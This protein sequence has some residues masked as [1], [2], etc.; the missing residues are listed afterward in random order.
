[1]RLAL[2]VLI[3]GCVGCGGDPEGPDQTIEIL[4]GGPILCPDGQA[5]PFGTSAPRCSDGMFCT[6]REVH[7]STDP[8]GI[9]CGTNPGETTCIASYPFG[10]TVHLTVAGGRGAGCYFLT[11]AITPTVQ[12]TAP[13]DFQLPMDTSYTVMLGC[14]NP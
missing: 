4:N 9:V 1:M 13:C 11:C 10:S 7:A 8:A 3:V 2:V 12:S 6:Q 5:C 14:Y